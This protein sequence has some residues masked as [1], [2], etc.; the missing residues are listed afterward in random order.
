VVE[1]EAEAAEEESSCLRSDFRLV[2]VVSIGVEEPES[3]AAAA[4]EAEAVELAES[5][6][7][8]RDFDFDG[9]FRV[10]S[11]ELLV[12]CFDPD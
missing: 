11:L 4:G 6:L 9:G 3:V 12:G 8:E 10:A 2:L 5:F 1:L 7:A